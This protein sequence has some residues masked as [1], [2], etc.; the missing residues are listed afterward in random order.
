MNKLKQ[1]LNM[2]DRMLKEK[3]MFYNLILKYVN[4]N[5]NFLVKINQTIFATAMIK[6][7]F[8]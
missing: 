3:F 4:Q 1:N 5:Q 6:N 2:D 8:T 7:I